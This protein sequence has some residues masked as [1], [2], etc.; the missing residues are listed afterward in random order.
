M[1]VIRASTA[2][3]VRVAV[4]GDWHSNRHG[5]RVALGR[6]HDRAP[7][8][9]TVLQLGDFNLGSGR[10]WADYC[11]SLDQAMTQF[12]IER[13]LITP[14]N[15]DDW[16][17]LS[18]RFA[19]HPGQPY[20]PPRLR[21]IALLPRGFRFSIEQRSFVSFGGAAS[22]DQER[23][24]QGKDWWPEEEP[25]LAE[26][27]ATILG[28]TADVMLSHEAVNGGTLRV[29][30]ALTR[31]NP[32]LFSQHGLQASRRSRAHVTQVWNRIK[33]MVLLHGHMHLQAEGQ[34]P[35][36]RRVY[37]LAANNTAGNIGVLDLRDLSWEWLD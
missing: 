16:G 1:A 15:H 7:D 14:G 28:G 37:S 34:H 25:T 5:V 6:L 17:Q 32:S 33:P 20:I 11:K 4:A 3:D 30:A 35:G 13:I 18:K 31:P 19:S 12:G 23:R 29:D 10:P 2:S 26:T 24:I 9:R 22:P 8:V 36:G 21:T 27:E